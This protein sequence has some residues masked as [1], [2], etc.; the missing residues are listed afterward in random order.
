MSQT[1]FAEL[2][3]AAKKR[4]T[5]REQFLGRLDCLLPWQEL[6]NLIAPHY[7]ATGGRGRQPYPLRLMLRL[8]VVQV[9]E[10]LSDP[11][12]EDAI[13]DSLSVQRFLGL[14]PLDAIPDETTILN[15]RHRLEAAALGRGLLEEI[16]RHLEAEG[17]QLRPQSGTVVDASI[18]SAPT[19]TRNRDQAR[20]PEMHQTKKGNQWYFGMKLHIGVDSESGIVHRLHTTAA[21]VS[22]VTEVDHLLHRNDRLVCGDAGYQ[23]IAKRPEH[24]E[25]KVTWQVA[26]RPGKRRLLDQEGEEWLEEKRKASVR[27]KVEHPFQIVKVR[28]GYARVRYRGLFKNTQ[29]LALLLGLA[30]VV[31]AERQLVA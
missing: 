30:N 13:Y 25:R 16:N 19:S 7:P 15:F 26:M 3:Y 5:R 31:R 8:H 12:M 21:N 28:F 4:V 29:R 18:I 20:D 9:V 23:G 1:T 6:E 24:R 22:D 10:N 14:R 27:A 2:D 17:L 11:G